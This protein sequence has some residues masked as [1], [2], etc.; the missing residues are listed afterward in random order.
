MDC[1]E[2]KYLK[3][4]SKTSTFQASSVRRDRKKLTTIIVYSSNTVSHG[5]STVHIC[6]KIDAKIY[7]TLKTGFRRLNSKFCHLKRESGIC[8]GSSCV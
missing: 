4:T 6:Y 3:N 2:F 8:I 5:N 1:E 7:D